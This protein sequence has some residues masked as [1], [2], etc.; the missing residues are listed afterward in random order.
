MRQVVVELSEGWEVV[1]CM[2]VH[3]TRGMCMPEHTSLGRPPRAWERP[4]TAAAAAPP[5]PTT[6]DVQPQPLVATAASVGPPV[7]VGVGG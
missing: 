4:A 5:R 6:S 3:G 1:I 2:H 7:R